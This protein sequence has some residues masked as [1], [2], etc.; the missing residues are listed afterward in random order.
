MMMKDFLDFDMKGVLML[1]VELPP[2][3]CSHFLRSYKVRCTMSYKGISDIAYKL[4]MNF[5]LFTILI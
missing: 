2:M 1:N 5:S 3:G 4:Y